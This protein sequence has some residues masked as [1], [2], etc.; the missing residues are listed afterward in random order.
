[1]PFLPIEPTSLHR[2]QQFPENV[3]KFDALF[4][5]HII[6]SCSVSPASMRC[7][8]ACISHLPER[9]EDEAS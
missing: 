8:M 5:V 7:A 3:H 2:V 4:A 6:I 9:R 1:M